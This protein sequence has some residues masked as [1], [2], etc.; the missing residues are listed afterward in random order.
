VAIDGWQDAED[1][2][3]GA[4][5]SNEDIQAEPPENEDEPD[6]PLADIP[7][8]DAIFNAPDY[9]EIV[10][11]KQ[12][13]K[14]RKYERKV[15][16]VE[17]AIV[18]GAIKRKDFPDAA[19]ILKNGP[20]FARAVGDCAAQNDKVAG[21]VDML[22]SPDNPTIVMAI[23][24]FALVSQLFRN[25]QPEI[26]EMTAKAKVGWKRRRELRKTGT[27][28]VN[29]REPLATTTF[30]LPFR[31]KPVTIRWRVRIPIFASLSRGLFA[32]AVDPVVLTH[33]VFSDEN[34]QK[35]LQK[36]G[37]IIGVRT[38]DGV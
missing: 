22:T 18:I 15:Q 26:E 16:S 8:Y 19:A 37:I 17:K 38:D 10:G 4:P 2:D 23:T 28:L 31:K 34:V 7:G 27:K 25:H 20:A 3:F 5:L 9:A 36:Q 1:L 32:S 14:S 29:E 12:S 21:Y 11:T 13:T 35:A 24:G 6:E 30:K 33:S